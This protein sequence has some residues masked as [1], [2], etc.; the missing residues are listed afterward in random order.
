MATLTFYLF[1]EAIRTR[2]FNRKVLTAAT[3]TF[4]LAY[5]SWEGTG[6]ILPAL[7]LGLAV[8]RWGEWW[9]LKEFHLYRCLFFI[10][11]V[12][13]AQY[14]SR[15]YAGSPYLLVGSGLS[16]LTGP[17]L[18]FLAPGYQPMFYVDKL[19]LSENHVFFTVMFLLGLPFCWKQP[20]FRYVFVL[21][22][23]LF[24]LH[25]NF[26]AALSPR[27]CYY[28]QPLVILGGVA[29]ASCL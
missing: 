17:S 2:P 4:C 14:C 3:V 24:T 13:V 7:L 27:Y 15:M 6:F 11:A 12:V 19:L 25:T 29:A 9:W 26:L 22:A 8:V 18:F 1:Y 28:Y 21:L 10:G 20:G 5:L 16:N 23:T